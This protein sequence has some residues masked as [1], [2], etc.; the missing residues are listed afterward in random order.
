MGFLFGVE[1]GFSAFGHMRQLVVI[2]SRG[3][4]TD[5]FRRHEPKQTCVLVS[6]TCWRFFRRCCVVD[7]AEREQRQ[8]FIQGPGS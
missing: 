8:Q 4:S 2:E 3:D 7:N 1:R 6:G 5:H